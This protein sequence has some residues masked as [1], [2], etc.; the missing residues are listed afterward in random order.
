MIFYAFVDILS[1]MHEQQPGQVSIEEIFLSMVNVETGNIG[2]EELLNKIGYEIS[3]DNRSDG[4]IFWISA[5]RKTALTRNVPP[6]ALILSQDGLLHAPKYDQSFVD[7]TPRMKL[8]TIEIPSFDNKVVFSFE[9]VANKE[10]IRTIV[11]STEHKRKI[12]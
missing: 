1:G 3:S 5:S 12:S 7:E 8:T 11:L 9:G 10:E 4:R 2:F 6:V